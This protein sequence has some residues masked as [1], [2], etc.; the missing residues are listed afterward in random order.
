M[1]RLDKL[2]CNIIKDLLPSYLENICSA[3]TKHAVEEHLAI[4]NTCRNL[5]AMMQK[6]D[7]KSERTESAEID[8]M[9]K[10]KRYFLKKNS[11]GIILSI[12]VL[13]S[14]FQGISSYNTYPLQ[15]YYCLLPCLLVA[16]KVLFHSAPPTQKI[17]KFWKIM[18]YLGILL[19]CY[20]IFIT[21]YAFTHMEHWVLQGY[22]PFHLKPEQIGP[23]LHWQ[24]L[25]ILFYLCMLY[26]IEVYRT[27][28]GKPSN[29]LDINL[30]LTCGFILIGEDKILR[31]LSDLSTFYYTLLQTILIF[32]LEGI[33]I[34]MLFAFLEKRNHN[35]LQRKGSCR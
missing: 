3:D 27:I 11:Y 9:K 7:F 25:I 4:C 8:Y 16:S 22:M 10:T 32:L 29:F 23:F 6:T 30:Y 35:H 19:T 26:L 15:V 5:T 1:S 17:K 12:F 14:F 34:A 24:F 33:A 2:N 31:I 13:L 28:C 21:I 18:T 20:S